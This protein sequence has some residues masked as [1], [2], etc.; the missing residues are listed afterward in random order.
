MIGKHG[1]SEPPSPIGVS[2][3]RS[4]R[5]YWNFAS[6]FSRWEPPLRLDMPAEPARAATARTLRRAGR[7]GPL[8]E[9]GH[10]AIFSTGSF[11]WSS[12]TF[13]PS[14]GL[15]STHSS[16]APTGRQGSVAM[17]PWEC[18]DIVV[19]DNFEYMV[20]LR[21]RSPESALSCW[22]SILMTKSASLFTADSPNSCL[23][24]NTRR[25]PRRLPLRAATFGPR[26]DVW[27]SIS[28][29]WRMRRV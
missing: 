25:R 13:L 28:S 14:A 18:D 26:R 21:N 8:A 6:A 3:D 5:T 17:P 9:I 23:P 11:S 2:F 1:G 20:R 10:R 24:S 19:C 7:T 15:P 29:V 4:Q 27:W 16:L 22:K 12:N